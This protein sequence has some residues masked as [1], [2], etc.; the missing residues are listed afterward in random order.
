MANRNRAVKDVPE[1]GLLASLSSITESAKC[2]GAGNVRC[3]MSRRPNKAFDLFVCQ[4]F[5]LKGLGISAARQDAPIMRSQNRGA[6]RPL[7]NLFQDLLSYA[8][9]KRC[10]R[11]SNSTLKSRVGRNEVVSEYAVRRG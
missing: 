1:P 3:P 9:M 10:T 6:K 5:P 2:P 11:A 4:A 8:D 7:R